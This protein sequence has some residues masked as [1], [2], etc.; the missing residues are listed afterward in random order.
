MGAASSIIAILPASLGVLGASTIPAVTQNPGISG[1]IS[2]ALI[3][4][5]AILAFQ[6][7]LA[8]IGICFPFE[9]R[10][11]RSVET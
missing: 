11:T 2:F 8:L 4:L 1:S 9:A 3:P 10:H 6:A 7:G 5:A